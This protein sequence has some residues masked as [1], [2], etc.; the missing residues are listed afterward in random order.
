M[1]SKN[2]FNE[3]SFNDKGGEEKILI[4]AEKDLEENINNNK[5][6]TIEKGDFNINLK[7]GDSSLKIKDGNYDVIISDNLI[8][9][10]IMPN[11]IR[12][13]TVAPSL[14]TITAPITVLKIK[15]KIHARQ[16]LFSSSLIS[17]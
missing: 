16:P 8:I 3:I 14:P 17:L 6:I 13:H 1:N 4:R 10:H 5:N 12:K 11:V 7:K 15:K 9:K 2:G